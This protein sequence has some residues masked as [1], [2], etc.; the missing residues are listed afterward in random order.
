MAVVSTDHADESMCVRHLDVQDES[1]KPRIISAEEIEKHNERKGEESFW[2]VIDGFVVDVKA[3]IDKHPGGAR[4]ILSTDSAKVGATG[5]KFG[6]SFTRGRN[7]H[8]P[9]T[10]KR[11]QDGVKAYLTQRGTGRILPPTDVSFPPHGKITIVG[12]LSR[13]A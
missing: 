5:Q 6:F 11:F 12:K 3:F 1:T 4:K 9:N 2:C 8:F 10:G 7:A 13:T